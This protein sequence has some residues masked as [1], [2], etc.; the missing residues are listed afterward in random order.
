M[1]NE[2]EVIHQQMEETRA[3]LQDKLETLEQQV[4]ETVQG[5]TQAA[6]GTVEAVKDTVETVKETVQGTVETVKE[7]V[8]ETVQTVKET[9]SLSRLV[10]EYPWPMLAGAAVI[11]YAGGRLLVSSRDNRQLGA[12]EFVEQPVSAPPALPRRSWWNWVTD[13]YADE[14][15]KLKGLAIAA[16]GNIVREMVTENLPPDLAGK[17]GEFID[18]IVTKLGAEPIEEPLIKPE[19]QEERSEELDES[20]PTPAAEQW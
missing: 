11:G 18:G 14:I 10:N 6:L 17:T 5:T 2:A 13:H 9:L 8:Q 4:K 15:S 1:A 12:Y 7:T 16:T 3:A 19:H 20:R